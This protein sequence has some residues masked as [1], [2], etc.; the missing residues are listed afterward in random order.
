MKKVLFD[1]SALRNR[2]LCQ[3]GTLKAFSEKVEMSHSCVSNRLSDKTQF[4]I[5]DVEKWAAAL[6]LNTNEIGSL[7]FCVRCA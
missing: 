6:D 4:T 1:Y 3:F 2:I 7:F 5:D